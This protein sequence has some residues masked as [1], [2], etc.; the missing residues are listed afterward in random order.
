MGINTC[1]CVVAEANRKGGEIVP[2]EKRSFSRDHEL[3]AEAGRKGGESREQDRRPAHGSRTD[4]AGLRP[5]YELQRTGPTFCDLRT[6]SI[7]CP[8]A[9]SSKSCLVW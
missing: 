4:A 8:T 7:K 6:L 5:S 9:M 3:A 1:R 2:D